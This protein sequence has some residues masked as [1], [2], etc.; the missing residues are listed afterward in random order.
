[1]K[2]KVRKVKRVSLIER[3]MRWLFNKELLMNKVISSVMML[4]GYLSIS[5]DGDCTAFVLTLFF[6]LPIFFAKENF[7]SD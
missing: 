1:M 4:L 5:I 7:I 3:I 2:K 6:G